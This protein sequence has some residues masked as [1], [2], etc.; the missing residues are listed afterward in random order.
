MDYIKISEHEFPTMLAITAEEQEQGL[1]FKKWPPP[2][3][4]F[5]YGEPRI[6]KFWMKGTPSPL[7]IIFCH[8][9]KVISIES[10]EPYSTKIIGDN[11][12]SDLVIE[13]PLG[14]CK[15]HEIK[16]GNSVELK[17]C[18]D[19]LMKIFMRKNGLLI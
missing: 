5:V 1:M 3:M 14:T 10:G 2:V 8:A 12:F 6:N 11:R 15:A 4:V 17:C 16:I 18:Q 19:S 13:M 9:G 7:D